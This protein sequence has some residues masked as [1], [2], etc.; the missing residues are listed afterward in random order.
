MGAFIHLLALLVIAL[1]V[2]ALSAVC[3]S[4]LRL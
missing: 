4:N 3:V 2:P 1:V